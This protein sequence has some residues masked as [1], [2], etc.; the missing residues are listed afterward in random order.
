MVLIAACISARI[1]WI[2]AITGPIAT[3]IFGKMG[4]TQEQQ[5]QFVNLRYEIERR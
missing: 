1:S 5:E 2:E 3:P 4:L